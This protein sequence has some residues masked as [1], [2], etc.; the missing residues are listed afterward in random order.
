MIEVVVSRSAGTITTIRAWRFGKSGLP[1]TKKM[2]ARPHITKIAAKVFAIISSSCI[3]TSFTIE[4]AVRGE[5]RFLMIPLSKR[6]Y[7]TVTLPE[8]LTG[9][10]S[11]GRPHIA[12]DLLSQKVAAAGGIPAACGFVSVLIRDQEVRH[13]RLDSRQ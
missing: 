8:G 13:A 10:F 12:L 9:G 11:E 3:A 4:P 6:L 5:R 2:R 1:A 7:S